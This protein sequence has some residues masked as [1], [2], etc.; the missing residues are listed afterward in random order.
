MDKAAMLAA[1]ITGL[2]D[3]SDMAFISQRNQLKEE[4]VDLFN[5]RHAPTIYQ[6]NPTT[7]NFQERNHRVPPHCKRRG[8]RCLVCYTLHKLPFEQDVSFVYCLTS[9]LAGNPTMPSTG[10][11][12][13][14]FQDDYWLREYLRTFL[15]LGGSWRQGS[16]KKCLRFDF[17]RDPPKPDCQTCA[18]LLEGICHLVD[19]STLLCGNP[20]RVDITASSEEG[21]SAIFGDQK[22]EFYS[23]PGMYFVFGSPFCQLSLLSLWITR[24]SSQYHRSDDYR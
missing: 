8:H 7:Q 13:E 4:I 12:D 15:E 3:Y 17:P 5:L 10:E 11:N 9:F 6:R 14:L 1:K 18:L 16:P 24:L 23:L 21:L 22:I 19:P 20:S 2:Q